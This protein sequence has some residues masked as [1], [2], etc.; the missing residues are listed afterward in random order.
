M[1]IGKNDFRKLLNGREEN[2]E[3]ND[4]AEKD[5]LV[6]YHVNKKSKV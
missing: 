4:A 1:Q 5:V 6:I 3:G 2:Q